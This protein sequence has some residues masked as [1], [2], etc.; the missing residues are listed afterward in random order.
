MLARH[1]KLYRI[2]VLCCKQMEILLVLPNIFSV[3]LIWSTQH[4]QSIASCYTCEKLLYLFNSFFNFNFVFLFLLTLD[5]TVLCHWNFFFFS[6]SFALQSIKTA[7]LA[8][9]ACLVTAE[10]EFKLCEK[11]MKEKF[12][13]AALT[14]LNIPCCVTV[15]FLE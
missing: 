13:P 11:I 9:A 3:F 15:L 8:G 6:F 5:A 14:F 2:V 4:K 10:A 7:G 1:T 12:L